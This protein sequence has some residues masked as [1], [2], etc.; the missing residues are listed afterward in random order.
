MLF[1]L[2]GV[3]TLWLLAVAVSM[4]VHTFSVPSDLS[5]A[6]LLLM[7]AVGFL[8]TRALLG[9]GAGGNGRPNES[10][11][12]AAGPGGPRQHDDADRGVEIRGKSG[13]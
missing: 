10:P 9:N 11:G 7:P 5:R 2:T 8:L 6:A 4:A 1:V 12:G 13:P 3:E